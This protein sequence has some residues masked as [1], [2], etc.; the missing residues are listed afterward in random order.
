MKTSFETK[1]EKEKLN[2]VS[3][4]KIFDYIIL[5]IYLLNF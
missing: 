5:F 2:N 3:Y 1:R 4:N